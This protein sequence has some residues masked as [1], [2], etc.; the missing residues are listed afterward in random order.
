VDG[1]DSETNT[2]YEFY[3]DYYHGNPKIYKKDDVNPT[4]KC[5][6]G[7]LYENTQKREQDLKNAGYN[8]ISV[9]ES[10]WKILIKE[11]GSYVSELL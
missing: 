4:T 9:W 10:D 3:G 6:Y 7:L 1:F 8:V 5:S 11:R 2:V